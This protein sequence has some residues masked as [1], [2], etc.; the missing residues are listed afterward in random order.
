MK[1]T[2][3]LLL[4]LV[5]TA[6]NSNPVFAAKND[7]VLILE[8]IVLSIKPLAP[9]AT[10]DA[11]ENIPDADITQLKQLVR[12]QVTRIRRGILKENRKLKEGSLVEGMF[13][14]RDSLKEY[15]HRLSRKDLED[16]KFKV[17]VTDSVRALNL[18]P[19]E[20]GFARYKL[21]LKRYNKEETTFILDRYEKLKPAKTSYI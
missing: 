7:I 9:P 11:I 6:G 18:K 19:E 4:A 14:G 13:L 12:F 5:L 20:A 17:A 1:K 2:F 3:L 10:A 16:L 21:Y 8:G 15:D